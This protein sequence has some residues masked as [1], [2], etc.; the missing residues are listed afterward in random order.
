[1]SYSASKYW[2]LFYSA[3]CRQVRAGAQCCSV[4][5]QKH[6]PPGRP[7]GS[8]KIDTGM[9][10]IRLQGSLQCQRC[11]HYAFWW[12]VSIPAM[13]QHPWY[14]I[15]IWTGWPHLGDVCQTQLNGWQWASSWVNFA[16]L[17]ILSSHLVL[18]A[19]CSIKASRNNGRLESSDLTHV[20]GI[21]ADNLEIRR[22]HISH[23]A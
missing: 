19:P 5:G 8:T 6:V 3:V 4:P 23:P 14:P 9:Q 12:L 18:T 22:H 7:K 21:N 15:R 1:M 17:T 10:T 11:L 13:P 2:N 16:V 20:V